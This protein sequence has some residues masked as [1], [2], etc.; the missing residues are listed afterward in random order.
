MAWMWL[1]LAGMCEMVWPLGF[2]FTHGFTTRYWAVAITFAIMIL[3]FYLMSLATRGGIPVGTTYAVWTGIGA[4]GTALLGILLFGEP[5][6]AM[7]LVCL[8]LIICGAVGLKFLSP[9]E[10]TAATQDAP[11]APREVQG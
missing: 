8:S 3:S 7:R 6:D 5:R 11:T 9:P 1:L 4:A 2:K 10:Q